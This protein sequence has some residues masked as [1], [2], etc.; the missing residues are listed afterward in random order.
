M[1]RETVVPPETI[2]P[3]GD[4]VSPKGDIAL[5][6]KSINEH[7]VYTSNPVYEMVRKNANTF[8]YINTC[9]NIL[10][11]HMKFRH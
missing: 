10:S 8:S 11:T 5:H 7:H 1:S 4:I 3:K 2:S 6:D 9:N